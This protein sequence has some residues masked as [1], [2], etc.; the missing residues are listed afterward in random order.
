[1]LDF[2]SERPHDDGSVVIV[3]QHKLLQ[4]R[5]VVFLELF[6]V[7][8]FNEG[9]TPFV[10]NHHAGLVG[11]VEHIL[12]D[13][14]VGGT[15]NVVPFPAEFLEPLTRTGAVPVLGRIT[16]EVERMGAFHKQ[17][18]GLTVQRESG[19]SRPEV[20]KSETLQPNR[21]NGVSATKI[22]RAIIEVGRVW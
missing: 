2:V 14:M 18:N 19:I 8:L 21:R 20:T 6:L 22:K 10:I 16:A 7:N 13:R 9:K 15:K 12:P 1:M 5:K 4:F 17:G 3:L 11:S